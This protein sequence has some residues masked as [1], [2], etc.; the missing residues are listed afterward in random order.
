MVQAGAGE[1]S[2]V[3]YQD[4]IGAGANIVSSVDDIFK[5]AEL[6][7]KVKEPLP[8][9]RV[10]LRRGQGIFT[11]LHLA[12]EPDQA[13]DLLDSGVT[14]IAD[15][16]VTDPAGRLPLLAPM[17][18]VAGR[19]AAQVAAH[20]LQRPHGG[21]GILLGS[22]DG[23]APAEVVVFG[24]GVVGSN[25]ALMA[26]AMGANVTVTVKTEQ[27]AARLRRQFDGRHRS[28]GQRI[29]CRFESLTG[30]HDPEEA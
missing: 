30:A 4:Y 24:G 20:F 16:T 6:I 12:A 13:R 9:E 8:E 25:A 23:G 19:M 5:A 1:G 29:E 14:A 15:E 11:Y 7:V 28:H 17:S 22:V 26:S 10:K 2:G 27:S 3:S 21:R 18:R